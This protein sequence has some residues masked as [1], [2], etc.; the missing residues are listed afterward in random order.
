MSLNFCDTKPFS[1]CMNNF[2]AFQFH[3]EQKKFGNRISRVSTKSDLND[4]SFVTKL[5]ATKLCKRL[6][7]QILAGII[8]NVLSVIR[9]QLS[10]SI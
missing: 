7:N 8:C 10:E 4:K 1:I 2:G 6:P 3:A 9:L 5:F